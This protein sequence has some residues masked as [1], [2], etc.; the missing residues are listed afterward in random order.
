MYASGE[1]VGVRHDTS[2]NDINFSPKPGLDTVE[3]SSSRNEQGSQNAGDRVSANQAVTFLVWN[4]GGLAS[5]LGDTDFTSYVTKFDIVCFIETFIDATFDLSLHFTD[6]VKYMSPAIKLSQQGRRSGGIVFMC[7]KNIAKYVELIDSARDHIL[8]LKLSKD[9]YGGDRDTVFMPVYVPPTGSPYYQTIETTCQ[10]QEAELCLS[11]ALESAGDVN[12]LVCGDLNARTSDYQVNTQNIFD[13]LDQ[14][15]HVED[16]DTISHGRATEDK[17]L[18][19]FGTKLINFCVCFD[20]SILNGV[21]N[22]DS[23]CKYT[24]VSPSGNS[25]V[26]YCLASADIALSIKDLTIGSRVESMHMPVEFVLG[27]QGNQTQPPK[28][29]PFEKIV[30]N[31]AKREDFIE[32]VSSHDFADTLKTACEAVSS[33]IDEGLEV[34]TKGMLN[35]AR[36]MVRRVSGDIENKGAS[37]WFDLECLEKKRS[38]RRLLRSCQ[39]VEKQNTK[40]KE[41]AKQ[42]YVEARKEYKDLLRTKRA[43][44]RQKQVNSILDSA[45]NPKEFWK[46]IRKCN[47][48]E[49]HSSS[50]PKDAWYEHLRLF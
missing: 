34:F 43:E 32:S 18:N 10:L 6:Y 45:D 24:F 14:D 15:L 23:S 8:V 50:V 26:D 40:E 7:R 27:T 42:R 3:N 20:L 30:W 5:Q 21:C 49:M 29:A 48:K 47:R 28:Q 35:S 36:C 12:T 11:D 25:V 31:D 22:T 2:Q 9:M 19:S 39:R 1:S 16:H 4:V 17:T 33:D 44:H 37:S 46:E 38:A 13:L 41:A